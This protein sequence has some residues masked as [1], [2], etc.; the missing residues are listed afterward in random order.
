MNC[1][2]PIETTAEQ[3]KTK[4]PLNSNTVESSTS[5]VEWRNQTFTGLSLPFDFHQHSPCSHSQGPSLTVCPKLP[6]PWTDPWVVTSKPIEAQQPRGGRKTLLRPAA[7]NQQR[8]RLLV[9]VG[10]L[11]L[12]GQ[13]ADWEVVNH[14][15]DLLHVVLEAVVALPQG[16]VFQVEQAEARVQ[17]VD[18][19]GDSQWAIVVSRRDAVHR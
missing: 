4:M 2:T 3:N 13:T 7:A 9:R 15:L 16:V 8:S 6:G 5:R 14:L 1:A 19:V 10:R 11:G 18:E 17:L 12:L